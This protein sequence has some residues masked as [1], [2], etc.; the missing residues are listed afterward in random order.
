MSNVLTHAALGRLGSANLSRV[1]GAI[2]LTVNPPQ[3]LS[4]SRVCALVELLC[5]LCVAEAV[6]RG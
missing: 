1:A 2:I 5:V 4:V 6:G 3:L